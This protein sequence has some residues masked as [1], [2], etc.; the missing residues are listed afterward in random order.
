MFG[1][2]YVLSW[3]LVTWLGANR[4]VLQPF[5]HLWEDK[6]ISEMIKFG[7]KAE[8]CWISVDSEYMLLLGSWENP[9][10]Y[11]WV[12]PLGPDVILV[13]GLKSDLLLGEVIDYYLGN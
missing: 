10:P 11:T 12:R 4:E 1:P 5:M 8:E 9:A 7:G 13:H 2:G 6:S 3:D